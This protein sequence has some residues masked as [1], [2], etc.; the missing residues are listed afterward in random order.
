MSEPTEVR[1]RQFLKTSVG[2]LA[3]APALLSQR[4]PNETI[5]VASI[6]VGTRGH[7][8]LQEAQE[9][10]NTEIRVICDLYE[11]NIK[12]AQK[13]AMNKNARVIKEWER[14]MEDKDVDAV[15]IGTPDFWHAPMCIRASEA[16][17][18][19]YVEKGWCLNARE[20]KAMRKAIKDNKVVMQLG[21]QYNSLP[22]FHK[23][24]EIYQ[25]GRLGK[26]PTVRMYIDR[27]GPYPEWQFYT[28]YDINQLPADATAENIDWQRFQAQASKKGPF[29]P[30][31][32]FRWRCWWEY[33]NGIAG[34]LMS[35]LWDSVNMVTGAGIPESCVTQGSL[36]FWKQDRQVP[37]QWHVLFDYPKKELAMMFGCVFQNRHV[38]EVIQYLGRDQTL[39]VAPNFCRTFIGEWTQEY[40]EKK[41]P[42]QRRQGEKIGLMPQ[43]AP[44]IPDYSLK[45]NELE[46]SSHMRNFIDCIR[47]GETPRC[48]V[49]RAFEEAVTIN[50]SV[51]AFRR[52]RRV[53]WDPVK[54]EIV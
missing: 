50:M 8:L 15:L 11:G 34:D 4:S 48:G 7:Q 21:H 32:F 22:Q 53:R 23:A 37:D 40:M 13:L 6:G 29:D 24:R 18:H 17:K 10:P 51:E 2:A 27:T 46:V 38:G 25:S 41:N 28:F 3:G 14:V 33:G 54:E 35:H 5:G 45:P 26:V 47:S 20:A 36:Y 44:Q 30:E 52:D 12:R 19:S 39:E 16:R 49:D 43:D 42:W 9:C 1:R 31:R